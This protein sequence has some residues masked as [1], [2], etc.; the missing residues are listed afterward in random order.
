MRTMV[1]GQK[2]SSVIDSLRADNNRE[3]NSAKGIVLPRM[4]AIYVAHSSLRR[5]HF[6]S[7]RV[8]QRICAVLITLM[9]GRVATLFGLQSC[10]EYSI[11]HIVVT[12]YAPLEPFIPTH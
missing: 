9:W 2:K 10:R 6:T 3:V 7:L 12:I 5:L 8:V 11:G 1:V 4:L